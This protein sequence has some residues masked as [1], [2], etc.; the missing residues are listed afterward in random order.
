MVVEDLIL[1]VFFIKGFSVLPGLVFGG[2]M[3]LI[4]HF[5][6]Y[7]SS[8]LLNYNHFCVFKYKL[9]CDMYVISGFLLS[10]KY[11]K[12]I[13]LVL[14]D[15]WVICKVREKYECLNSYKV[16]PTNTNLGCQ[17]VDQFMLKLAMFL[18]KIVWLRIIQMIRILKGCLSF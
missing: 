18:S 12:G 17:K 7:V 5:N 1:T 14:N 15:A 13:N 2:F 16:L 9:Y 4:H 11:M 6:T 8:V 3:V 10:I